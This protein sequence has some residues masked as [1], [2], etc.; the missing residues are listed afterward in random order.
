VQ[1]ALG[2]LV[3]KNGGRGLQ[4]FSKKF[5][6]QMITLIALSR[7]TEMKANNETKERNNR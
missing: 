2:N 5:S 6:I 1:H 4:A 3:S 7:L